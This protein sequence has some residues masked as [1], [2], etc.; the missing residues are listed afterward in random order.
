MTI[1]VIKI[2]TGIK[3]AV[4]NRNI[5]TGE[6]PQEQEHKVHEWM[7]HNVNRILSNAKHINS[8]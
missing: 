7:A 3:E 4:L 6:S 2:S 8:L 5:K 1:N